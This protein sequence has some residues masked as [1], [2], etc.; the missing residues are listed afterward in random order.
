L[1]F[2]DHF[3]IRP[4]IRFHSRNVG[5]ENNGLGESGTPVTEG[6]EYESGSNPH[7]LSVAELR[8]LNRAIGA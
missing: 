3:V 7:F 6:F 5:Y 1:E 2:D 8:E 4:T